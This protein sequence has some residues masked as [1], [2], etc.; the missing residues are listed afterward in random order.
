[1][2]KTAKKLTM[3]QTAIFIT[4][5]TIGNGTL[6][7]PRT[8]T[9]KLHSPDGWII[10]LILGIAF[11]IVSLLMLHVTC[12]TPTKTIFEL[13]QMIF[14]EIFGR[15][16]NILLVIYF[17]TLVIYQVRGLAEIIQFFLLSNTPI[18]VTIGVFL[19]VTI[20]H[21]RGGM[22]SISKVFSFLFPITFFV[23]FFLMGSSLKIFESSNLQPILEKNIFSSWTPYIDGFV[24]FSGFEVIFILIPFMQK[25][26]SAKKALIIGLTLP[27]LFYIT[28]LICVIGAM[29]V[30]ETIT[31]TWPTISLI[32]SFEIQGVFFQRFDM[33]LLTIWIFQFFSTATSVLSTTNIGIKT[34]IRSSRKNY[35]LLTLFLVPFI[36]CLIPNSIIAFFKFGHVLNYGFLFSFISM[37]FTYTVQFF[38]SRKRRVSL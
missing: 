32:Q 35:I 3:I 9:T 28:S 34:I 11:I 13:N 36:S 24:Y 8:I 16:L 10:V 18:F 23:Y 15:F 12:K 5:T 38:L 19:L 1:M 37:A 33:F 29:G 7:L 17:L 14:G 21:V 30:S 4:C 6:V 20:Y 26:E 22:Y 31:L 27:T 25:I 2:I